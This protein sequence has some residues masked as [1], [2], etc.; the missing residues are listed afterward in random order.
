MLLPG[1]FTLT[2]NGSGFM[3]GAQVLF[4]GVPLANDIY[5]RYATDGERAA[6][7]APSP[8]AGRGDGDES[9][10]G[11]GDFGGCRERAGGSAG[12]GT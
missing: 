10:P 2:V 3:P 1:A 4:G 5:I 11:L 9:G 12:V 7:R 8:G 6:P